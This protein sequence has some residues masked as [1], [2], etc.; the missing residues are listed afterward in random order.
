VSLITL[1]DENDSVVGSADYDVIHKNGLLHRFVLV[2]IFDKNGKFF[3][4]RRAMN[5]A[6]G[7]LLAESLCAHI[8]EGED[9]LQTAKRRMRE[10]LGLPSDNIELNEVTKLQVYTKEGDWKNNAFVKIYECIIDTVPIVNKSEVQEG[11]FSPLDEVR[12][13]F[14][15]NPAA[16]VP[17]FNTTFE[18]YLH[19][20]ELM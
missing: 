12:K 11:F 7:G 17:G 1:V 10:E 9:Y 6:H 20:K 13:K 14:I 18:A 4:Q 19:S 8:R 3:M 5:K 15:T 2:Y 16:F